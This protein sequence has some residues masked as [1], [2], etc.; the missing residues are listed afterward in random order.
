VRLLEICEPLFQY[1]CRLKRSARAGNAPDAQRI[2]GEVL[3]LLSEM[4]SQAA[5]ADPETQAAW[6][7]IE[8][9]LIFFVDFMVKEADP[10]LARTW[11]DIAHDRNEMAGEDKFFELLEQTLQ[12]SSGAAT[13]QLA[14]Y[15]TA[16]GLGFTGIYLDQPEYLHRLMDQCG[17]RLRGQMDANY[18]GPLIRDNELHVDESNLI[19][20]P[21]KSLI[22]WAIALVGLI[23]VL[24][25]SNAYLY[26]TGTQRLAASLDQIEQTAPVEPAVATTNP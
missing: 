2:R 20:P 15:Y 19:E 9:P 16:I 6:K 10:K 12:D 14:V 8:L 22:G 18:V 13:Q 4:Q 23:L 24:L 3:G 21:A 7:Q 26:R 17:A 1:T 5:A 11:K 25:V